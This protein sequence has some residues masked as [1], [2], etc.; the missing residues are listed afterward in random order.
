MAPAPTDSDV[1]TDAVR[2]R[3]DVHDGRVLTARAGSDGRVLWRTS[4]HRFASIGPT[5]RV[6]VIDRRGG[7]HGV[8]ALRWDGRLL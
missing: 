2:G 8:R 4:A 7:R 1:R 6:Y 5:G 3:V